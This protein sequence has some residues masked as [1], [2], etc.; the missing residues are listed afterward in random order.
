[1]RINEL[2][3]NQND[4]LINRIEALKAELNNRIDALKDLNQDNWDNALNEIQLIRGSVD[5]LDPRIDNLEEDLNSKITNLENDLENDLTSVKNNLE[6]N[7]NSVRD[8][9][10]DE[11]NSVKSDLT[12]TTDQLEVVDTKLQS[13]IDSLKSD[14][15]SLNNELSKCGNDLELIADN[16][17][18]IYTI[19]LKDRQDRQLGAV[20]LDLPLESLV[21]DISLT[22][23]SYLEVTKQSNNKLK[24]DLTALKLAHDHT[25]KDILDQIIGIAVPNGLATLDGNGDLHQ[26]ARRA[27]ADK[28]GTPFEQK[29]Q[30]INMAAPINGKTSVEECLSSL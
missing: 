16:D 26:V 2:I 18:Y 17:K 15:D 10:T 19:K 12:T 4:E 8:K 3:S 23:D 11:L 5:A 14:I 30:P 20:T 25:N 13:D 7:L 27:I 28:S 1:M 21:K 6:D 29:Y 9:L 22:S 24:I